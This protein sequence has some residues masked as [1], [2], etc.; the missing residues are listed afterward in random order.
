MKFLLVI[1]CIAVRSLLPAQSVA[2]QLGHS[3]LPADHI[4]LRYDHFT[5]SEINLAIGSFFQHSHDHTLN[6]SCYGA[7]LLAEYVS[8][9]SIDPLP[10]F[11]FRLGMGLVCQIE[12]EPWIY[13]DLSVWR[14]MNYGALCEASLDCNVSEVFRLYFFGQQKFLFS[15]QLGRTAFCFGAGMA[16][17]LNT[18]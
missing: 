13:K 5:N 18:F 3:L 11:N 1:F 17:R 14:R 9:R 4:A 15:K 2:L 8:N 16:I 6:Y 7:D 12:N 10:W